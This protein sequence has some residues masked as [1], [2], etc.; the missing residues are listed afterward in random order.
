LLFNPA[1]YAVPTGLTFGNSGRNSLNEPRRTNFDMG[2]FKHF[3]I[4]ESMTLEFRAEAFNVFNH[5]QWT[6][7]NNTTCG[8][9]FN[10]GAPDC[11]FGIPSQGTP[12]SNFL[13]PDG[14]HNPRIGE[15]ALKLLF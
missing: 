5:T 7:V 9:E 13:H 8:L 3:A 10:S 15:F 1:A 11:V 14:A 6:G 2:V 4:R 12:A